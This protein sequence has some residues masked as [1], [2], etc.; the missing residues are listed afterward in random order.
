MDV[1]WSFSLSTPTSVPCSIF[2]LKLPPQEWSPPLSSKLQINQPP[3]PFVASVHLNE[4]AWAALHQTIHNDTSSTLNLCRPFHILTTGEDPLNIDS[5]SLYS[6]LA[7]L[8]YCN[9]SSNTLVGFLLRSS[10]SPFFFLL[11][12]TC[13]IR[14]VTLAKLWNLK[15][16]TY[17][18]ECC[19]HWVSKS[20]AVC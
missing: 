15:S 20:V 11:K 8:E 18:S 6:F 10:A 3:M 16:S 7:P 1:L 13:N 5:H 12:Q 17:L 4:I 19:C 2:S 9:I 14:C